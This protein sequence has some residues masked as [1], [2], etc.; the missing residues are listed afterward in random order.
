MKKCL[1]RLLSA[2]CAALLLVSAASALTVEQAV[3][4]LETYY[5]DGLP[6]A[7]YEA[8]SLDE[9]FG[10]LGDPYTFYMDEKTYADFMGSVEGSESK[11]GI[12]VAVTYAETG[13]LINTVIPGGA[14]EE[15]GLKDG[16]TIIA[17]DGVSCV[18]GQESDV[19][20]IA[21]EEGTAVELTVAHADGTEEQFTVVR[22][23]FT[24]PTTSA[25]L[26]ENGS[27]YIDCNSFASNT[28]TMFSSGVAQLD[29]ETDLWL[30]D[31]RSNLGGV[32]ASAVEAAGV[33]T[34][35]AYLLYLRDGDGNY[36][37]YVNLEQYLTEAPAVVLTNFYSASAS[38]V[39]ASAIKDYGAGIVIG[40]RTY[41]KGVAQIVRDE[42]TD[43]ELFSGDA[44]KIT[45]YRFYSGAGNTTDTVGVLPTLLL[46]DEAV[47]A[48]ALLF[49]AQ[50]PQ[51]PEGWLR[52]TLG[53]WYFY[54]DA[55]AAQE[56][57]AG[58]AA[59]AEIFSALAP[60]VPAGVYVRNGWA[61][62]TAPM[63]ADYL[64]V[65]YQSRWFSDVAN[66]PYQTQL[67]TMATYKLLQGVGD[68]SFHPEEALTRAEL[69]SLL[70]Q[71]LGRA[72]FGENPFDD[73]PEDSWYAPYVTAMYNMGLVH[74]RGDGT[75]G[76]ED[77][78]TQ[79]EMITVLGNLT[80]FLNTGCRDQLAA[81]GEAELSNPGLADYDPWAKPYVWLLGQA[82]ADRGFTLLYAGVDEI[83]PQAV[84]LREE[85]GAALYQVLTELGILTW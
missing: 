4:L 76:P 39:F 49:H 73:V 5:V 75:F 83:D 81:A 17:I 22:R 6:Q 43:P 61:D 24:L 14:A 65:S 66:S 42:T 57:E 19:T 30:V 15:A 33:F 21:G 44:M 54:I 85:A 72:S 68:G 64:G 9:L 82:Y 26:L 70:A 55:A 28:G 34:G 32:S 63:A 80:A 52:L 16:D 53:G 48:A 79:Q 77:T 40:G 36:Y 51:D 38:E 7:A 10:V 37:P 56:D 59:L 3:E 29:G 71:A 60:G 11:V 78:L 45:A 46:R 1:T 25:S 18:P 2:V 23:S 8:E 62:V 47:N 20:R 67:N 41:G 50:E 74:G 58:R 35:P 69:C 12:G 13:I 31:L 84:V 27:G